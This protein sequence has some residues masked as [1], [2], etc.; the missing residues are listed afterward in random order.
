MPR[1]FYLSPQDVA[2]VARA[3]DRETWRLADNPQE[4]MLLWAAQNADKVLYMHEQQPLHGTTDYDLVAALRQQATCQGLG[5]TGS[6]K[7][8]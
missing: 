4:S 8:G 6:A 1:D 7:C 2:D 3:E 5:C